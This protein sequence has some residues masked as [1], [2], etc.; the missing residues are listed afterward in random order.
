[1]LAYSNLYKECNRV[2]KYKIVLLSCGKVLL[3]QQKMSIHSPWAQ[4]AIVTACQWLV[5]VVLKFESQFEFKST[6]AMKPI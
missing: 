2:K 3:N 4:T 1:M 5:G 6:L